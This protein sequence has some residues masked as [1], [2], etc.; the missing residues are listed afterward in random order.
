[1]G[2]TVGTGLGRS[3]PESGHLPREA[4]GGSSGPP[5]SADDKDFL[6]LLG[7]LS[8]AISVVTVVHQSLAAKEKA[9]VG[10]EEVALR[11]ALGLLRAA[12]SARDQASC[13]MADGRA[14]R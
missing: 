7:D 3:A 10:D 12:Y 6:I 11:H 8:D 2:S 14:A 4:A 9:S 5:H 1:M 13:R